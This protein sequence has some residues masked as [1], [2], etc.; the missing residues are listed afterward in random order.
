MILISTIISFLKDK[1]YRQLLFS[2]LIILGIGSVVYHYL[3]GW[4]WL[5]SFYF[6]V[7]TLTTIGYGDFSPQSTGGKIFTMF[8]ILIGIGIILTFV[9]TVFEHYNYVRKKEKNGKKK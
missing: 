8:Y 9:H 6:S 1:H 5:D 4:T 2:T 3:E 7:I